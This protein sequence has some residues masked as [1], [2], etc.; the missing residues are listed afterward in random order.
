MENI[1]GY[2]FTMNFNGLEL[3]DIEK[4]ISNEENF[5]TKFKNKLVTSWTGEATVNDTLF[6]LNFTARTNGNLSELLNISSDNLD[7]EAYTNEGEIMSVSIDFKPS[8]NLT[9]TKELGLKEFIVFPNPTSENINVNLNFKQETSF[10]LHLIN[11]L[12]QEVWKND[13]IGTD[14]KHKIDAS[15]LPSGSYFLKVFSGVG[16]DS[17]IMIL[18]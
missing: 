11:T 14:F 3:N 8:N 4:G 10:S 15:N 16:S 13:F 7:A 2:Q 5:N 18:Q 9:L 12:G 6:T 17:K 1:A